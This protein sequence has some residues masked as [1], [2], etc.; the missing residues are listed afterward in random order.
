[1]ELKVNGK[2][3]TS[4]EGKIP[5]QDLLGLSKAE[6][7]QLNHTQFPSQGIFVSKKV[8]NQKN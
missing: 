6:P 2:F 5:S 1:M 8:G 4:S 3:V 7:L